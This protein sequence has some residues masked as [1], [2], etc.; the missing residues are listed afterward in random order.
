MCIM[1]PI[2]HFLSEE[3]NVNVE[4]K[5]IKWICYLY[6]Y[7][8]FNFGRLRFNAKAEQKKKKCETKLIH[9]MRKSNYRKK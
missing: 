9:I 7:N 3:G 5:F 4:Q 6:L 2:N 1:Y 8:G